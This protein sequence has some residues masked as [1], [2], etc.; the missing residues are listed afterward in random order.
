MVYIP[1]SIPAGTVQG[2]ERR[3]SDLLQESSR[4]T[5]RGGER[6]QKTGGQPVL[7]HQSQGRDERADGED[8]EDDEPGISDSQAAAGGQSQSS[9]QS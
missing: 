7:T 8:D 1:V 4:G 6:I 2:R 5:S 3:S 9:H